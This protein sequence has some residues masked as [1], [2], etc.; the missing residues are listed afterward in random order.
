MC[1]TMLQMSRVNHLDSLGQLQT[2]RLDEQIRQAMIALSEKWTG[3]QIAFRLDSDAV[4]LQSN[5]DLLM[6]V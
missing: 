5:P 2:I 3:K 6:Q 1:D 4:I